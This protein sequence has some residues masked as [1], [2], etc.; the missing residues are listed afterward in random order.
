MVY[1]NMSLNFLLLLIATLLHLL[2]A[3]FIYSKNPKS[4]INLWFS[5]I[6][7][8]VALWAFTNAICF[9]VKTLG[10]AIF[11]SEIS[12]I[13]AIFIAA[14]FLYF[15]L[16]FPPEVSSLKK[17]LPK[18]YHK[19]YLIFSV[20]LVSIITL[21]PGFT[22]KTIILHPWKIITGTGLYV[23]AIYFLGTMGWGFLNLIR[24]YPFSRGIE[25]L[26]LKYLFLGAILSSF[27]GAIFN[28]ILPLFGNY[29]FVWL[30]PLFTFFLITFITLAITRY[31]L[32]EI[33]VILTEL[34][35]WLMGIL[36]FINVFVSRAT[37]DYIW[38][39]VTFF[40]FLIFAHYLIKAT[41]EEERRREKAERLDNEWQQLS[42]AENQFILSIYAHHLKILL[43]LRDIL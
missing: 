16:F 9:K 33:K 23:F 15:S 10:A 22:I 37:L 11:W 5:L 35:V 6:T 39:G 8:S 12:Y 17:Q 28:L 34:L 31:H 43:A 7:V 1:Q 3:I 21:I 18:R 24:K 19:I 30:G 26:Q 13:S 41:H 14:S 2:I 27:L 4:K 36:L 25:R 40:L 38:K 20:P 29:Q 32:F 42:K